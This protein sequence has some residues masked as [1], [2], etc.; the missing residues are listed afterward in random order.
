MGIEWS[1]MLGR[2]GTIEPVFVVRKVRKWV[3]GTFD[4]QDAVEVASRS[5]DTQQRCGRRYTLV[6][7]WPSQA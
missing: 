7:H 2:S 5:A 1:T 4:C 6:A 3:E